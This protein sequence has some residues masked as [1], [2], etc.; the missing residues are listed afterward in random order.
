MLAERDAWAGAPGVLVDDDACCRRI[1]ISFLH[2][3]ANVAAANDLRRRAD[4]RERQCSRSRDGTK[5]C[6]PQHCHDCSCSS[7]LCL[8]GGYT[9]SPTSIPAHLFLP[10]IFFKGSRS[11]RVRKGGV[12]D[13]GQG[14]RFSNRE[15]HQRCLARRP[16][17]LGLGKAREFIVVGLSRPWL[18]RFGYRFASLANSLGRAHPLLPPL[19]LHRRSPVFPRGKADRTICKREDHG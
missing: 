10:L 7:V 17:G 1:F 3:P 9:A 16:P 12:P 6:F 19:W 11:T 5:K 13:D 14:T 4:S 8:C 18:E 15:H 2:V